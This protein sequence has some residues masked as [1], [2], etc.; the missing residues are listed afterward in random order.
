MDIVMTVTGIISG[1]KVIYDVYRD[2]RKK[3]QD[4]ASEK[5][6]LSLQK[7][8]HENGS[9]IQNEYDLDLRRLGETF[10]TGDGE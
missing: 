7:L 2:W 6:N 10:K 8:L 5:Q 4:R 3:R 1:F 9:K